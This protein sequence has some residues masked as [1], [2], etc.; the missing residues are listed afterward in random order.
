MCVSGDG[1][2]GLLQGKCTPSSGGLTCDFNECTTD[3]TCSDPANVCGCQ[4]ETYG[5][6][7]FGSVCVTA[8]CHVDADCGATGYCSPS[9]VPC[10]GAIGWYCH[11]C[12]DTCVNSSDCSPNATMGQS[13]LC[14][15][16]PTVGHWACATGICSG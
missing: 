4:G 10:G 5:D 9:L 11:T 16:D 15:Y 2:G 3:V 12:A 7:R 13:P 14:G 1:F 8:N 6:G